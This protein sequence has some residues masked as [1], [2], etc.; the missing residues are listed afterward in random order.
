MKKLLLSA[1]CILGAATGLAQDFKSQSFLAVQ[2]I[3]VTN[4]LG[5][6]N[7]LSPSNTYA[8]NNAGTVWT[9]LAGTRVIVSGSTGAAVNLLKTLDLPPDRNGNYS[10]LTWVPVYT[11]VLDNWIPSK[12]NLS[13][14]IKGQSG[15]NSAVTFVFAPVCDGSLENTATADLFKVA[16]TANT[17]SL[18][19]LSTNLPSHIW[20][21]CKSVRLREIVNADTDA[22]SRVDVLSV[23]LNSWQP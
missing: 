23:T 12:F 5:A 14:R 16:V 15:A 13:I 6:T 20:M 11:N 4:L 2:T 9:N 17:T 10:P 8:T 22:S 7:L 18:V 3:A 19:T 21:G 1:V